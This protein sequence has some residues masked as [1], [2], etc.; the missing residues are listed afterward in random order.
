MNIDITKLTPEQQL[1]LL[2]QLQQLQQPKA[3][4]KKEQEKEEKKEKKQQVKEEK[5]EKK[6][7]LANEIYRGE[8][9]RTEFHIRAAY[10]G[11]YIQFDILDVNS[12]ATFND[13]IAYLAN[14]IDVYSRYAW[15]IPMK[16]KNDWEYKIKDILDEIK[17]TNPENVKKIYKMRVKQGK[18]QEGTEDKTPYPENIFSDG[19][20]TAKAGNVVNEVEKRGINWVF[21]PPGDK[22]PLYVVERF[23]YA[24]RKLIVEHFEKEQ[25]S[26]YIDNLKEIVEKYNNLKNKTTKKTPFE[27]YKE[28][29]NW[30]DTRKD[31]KPRF[32]IG[33]YARLRLKINL[34]DK[35]SMTAKFS[36]EVYQIIGNATPY[37]FTIQRVDALNGK[38]NI[39]M[40][41]GYKPEQLKKINYDPVS[42]TEKPLSKEQKE[43]KEIE[44]E[45]KENKKLKRKLNKEGIEANFNY[46]DKQRPSRERKKVNYKV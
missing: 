23:N 11:Q 38:D 9:E 2:Q 40:P 27:I 32:Q 37:R 8:K 34:F 42:H 14:F 29:K 18:Q 24:L 19:E 46:F 10:C 43:E 26:R 20:A 17:N 6:T 35:L 28:E 1:L 33:D 36:R 41:E 5:K 12:R 21:I 30:K 39:V 44:Q 4:E 13:G 45:V 25:T 3:E 31:L 22:Y 7:N 16:K 15:V